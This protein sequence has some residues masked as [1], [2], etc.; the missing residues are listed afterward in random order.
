MANLS[1]WHCLSKI[2]L[3]TGEEKI[4]KLGERGEPGGRH[5]DTDTPPSPPRRNYI[6]VLVATPRSPT[7]H[8]KDKTKALKVPKKTDPYLFWNISCVE[9]GSYI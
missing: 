7:G 1:S 6:S 8:F 3:K 9:I 5:R 4:P 2:L